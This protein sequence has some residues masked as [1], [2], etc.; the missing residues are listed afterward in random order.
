[1][2][3]LLLMET[4]PVK[5]DLHLTLQFPP[6]VVMLLYVVAFG[7]Q[8]CAFLCVQRDRL[9]LRLRLRLRQAAAPQQPAAEG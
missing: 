1:M 7:R 3:P 8:A 5:S 9:R 2:L 6:H 4:A